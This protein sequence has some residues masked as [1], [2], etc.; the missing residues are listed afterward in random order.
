MDSG[1]TDV[2]IS[3]R[4]TCPPQLLIFDLKTDDIILRYR[5]PD[6]QVKQDSIFT[7]IVVDIRD[8]QCDD[9]Y[10]YITDSWR[11]ALIVYSLQRDQ[12][13]RIVNNLFY[14]DP[15]ASRYTLNGITWRWYDGVFGIALSPVDPDTNDRSLIYHPM[16]SF[17]EFVVPV[18]YIRNKTLADLNPDAFQPLGEP[19][20]IRNGQSSAQAM[21]RRGV[22]FQNLVTQDSVWCWNSQQAYGYKPELLGVVAQDNVT[23]NFPNDLKID[24]ELQQNLWVLSNRLPRYLYATLDYNDYNFRILTARTDKAV[25]GTVCDPNYDVVAQQLP[26]PQNRGSSFGFPF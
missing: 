11:Y 12:S 7:N 6:D 18:S 25:Q 21:D 17:R 1:I 4:Q 10:V 5:L 16:S 26:L 22:L 24:N 9:A 8:G 13:W 14:P 19:R 2:G 3:P 15:L 20:A 23:L